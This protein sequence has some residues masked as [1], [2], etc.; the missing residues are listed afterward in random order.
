MAGSE[1]APAEVAVRETGHLFLRIFAT[2]FPLLGALAGVLGALLT[3]T[4]S[5]IPWT[6]VPALIAIAAAISAVHARGE[7]AVYP[8]QVTMTPRELTLSYA[9]FH[10]EA[11]WEEWTA[12]GRSRMTGGTA[13]RTRWGSPKGYFVSPSQADSILRYR[14]APPAARPLGGPPGGGDGAGGTPPKG[15][16]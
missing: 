5:R 14:A 9:R 13:L 8:V 10:I 2:T 15:A 7:V 3:T 1:G 16:G 12:I 4:A 6:V 11:P